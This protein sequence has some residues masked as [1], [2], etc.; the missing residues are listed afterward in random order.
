MFQ[1]NLPVSSQG[2]TDK[3]NRFT[4]AD[5]DTWRKEKEKLETEMLKL[6]SVQQIINEERRCT[7]KSNDTN[8]IWRI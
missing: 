5:I 6:K 8:A 4:R 2:L 1:V 7:L 3:A